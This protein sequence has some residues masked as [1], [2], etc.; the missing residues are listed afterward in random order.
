MT[1]E[2]KIRI[3]RH[4]WDILERIYRELHDGG[5]SD[6]ALR[7]HWRE[8]HSFF[9]INSRVIE[10]D[11]RTVFREYIVTLQSLRFL[12]GHEGGTIGMAP[13]QTLLRAAAICE[14]R[15]H[16]AT[17]LRRAVWHRVCRILPSG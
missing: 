12:N 9:L 14:M 4:L 6:T 10:A 2:K 1:R 5:V 11:D 16:E 7:G 8:V 3:Y 15:E 13:S 17:Q